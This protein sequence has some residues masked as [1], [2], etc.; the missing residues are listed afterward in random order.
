M[1]TYDVEYF[2]RLFDK[3]FLYIKNFMRNVERY[4]NKIALIDGEKDK[5]WN[6]ETLNFEINKLAHALLENGIKPGDVIVYQLMNVPEFA[7]IYLASKKIGAIN[8]PINFKLSPGEIAYILDDSK[9]YV[10]IFQ[11]SLGEKIK[12]A[13]EISQHKP[14]VLIYV[15]D[16]TCD[17]GIPYNEFIE[18][19]PLSEPPESYCDAW[20][21]VTRLYTSGTTGRPKGI[22]LNNVNEILTCLEVILCLGLNREDI[23]LNLS[24][25]FHRGGVYLGGPSPGL[26]LGA[27]I[28]AMKLFSPKRALEIIEKYNVTFTVGVPSMYKL[29]VEEQ[30]KFSYNISSLRGALSMGAPLDKSLC[31]EM[32]EILTPNIFNG[33]GTSETFLNTLLIPE[34]LPGKAGTTGR[35]ITFFSDVRVVKVYPDKLAEPEELAERNNREVGEVIMRSL[36]GP[37]DYYNKPQERAKR[38]YKDWFY[39]GDLATWDEEGYLTIVSRKDDMII[40]G[41]ENIYPVQ[42]EEA[43]QEH[44][45]VLQCAVVGVPDELRGQAIVAYVVKKDE[46]LTL[47][48]L[49][50][51]INKHPMIPPHKRPRYWVFVDELP[52]T[53]TGKKQ[54]YKLREKVLK[55]LKKGLLM[56]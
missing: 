7:F 39:C 54:H 11:A 40:V 34:D 18:N 37:F 15:E 42:I 17:L 2:K 8:C 45:K 6:Y 28:I 47:E 30:K 16:G 53:A 55:D 23:L 22:P 51:F 52:M 12:N 50:E 20:A 36:T 13:L 14:K 3:N 1:Y 21:E 19:K 24:P 26:F 27:T 29:L 5:K 31:I 46:S 25:W 41:G 9:P 33:Y 4:K 38:V 10:F 43:I 49:K 56:R 44:P 32:K 48:E 35:N